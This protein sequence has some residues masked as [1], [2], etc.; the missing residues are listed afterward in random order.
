MKKIPT[1][2]LALAIAI[3]VEFVLLALV[4]FRL[5]IGPYGP[6][7]ALLFF[8]HFLAMLIIWTVS[9]L[10]VWLPWP[11]GLTFEAAVAI[12]NTLLNWGILSLLIRWVRKRRNARPQETGQEGSAAHD[13]TRHEKSGLPDVKA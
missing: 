3:V 11:P 12:S 9:I 8:T 1:A 7:N 2:I 4:G 10:S 5:G 13:E 6:E